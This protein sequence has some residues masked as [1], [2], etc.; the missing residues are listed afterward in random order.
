LK[1]A[2]SLAAGVLLLLAGCGGAPATPPTVTATVKTVTSKDPPY[3]ATLHLPQLAWAG[4]TAVADRVNAAVDAWAADQ[5]AAFGGRVATDLANARN[6]PASLP[7]SSMTV[8]YQVAQVT[9]S[10]VSFRFELEPY[11]RGAAHPE[12]NPA[13][14]TFNLKDGT[15]YSLDT[16]FKPGYTPTLVQAAAK[17]L[18][19]WTPAG[20]HCYLGKG[21][22]A[23]GAWWLAPGGLV[24]AFPAGQYTA[25]YCGPATVT[26][27]YASLKGIA[28]QGAPLG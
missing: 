5:V 27:P 15:A 20:A 10:V 14:L 28:A 3:T 4:H 17:G 13:G 11:V 24:L 21:P 9:A 23:L 6:L 7:E 1:V 26:V 19:S 8:T 22:T 18:A 25:S 2:A 12:Q 16:L